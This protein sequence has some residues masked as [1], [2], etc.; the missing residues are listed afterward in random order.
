V[1]LVE[2]AADLPEDVRDARGRLRS[3]GADEILERDPS[4]YSIA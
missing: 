3:V 4:R 1:R 2:R